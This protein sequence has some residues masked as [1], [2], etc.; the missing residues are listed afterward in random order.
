MSKPKTVTILGNRAMGKSVASVKR[1][2]EIEELVDKIMEAG[3]DIKTVSTEPKQLVSAASIE[4]FLN[5]L[6]KS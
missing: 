1:A 4:K 5:T 6:K 3:R 2:M